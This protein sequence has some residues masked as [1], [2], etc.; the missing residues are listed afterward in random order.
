LDKKLLEAK[1]VEAWRPQ[2]GEMHNDNAYS[3]II[4]RNIERANTLGHSPSV[5]GRS[6]S[7]ERSKAPLSPL[8]ALRSPLSAH[9]T[10]GKTLHTPVFLAHMSTRL[11]YVRFKSFPL[12][13][14]YPY[15][16]K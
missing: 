7:A 9:R 2:T 10:K 8:S 16:E 1:L 3:T 13:S 11:P 15:F 4:D 6:P 12:I 14:I 5:S